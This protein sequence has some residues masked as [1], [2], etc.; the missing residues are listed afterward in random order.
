MTFLLFIAVS[1][2]A[3]R[4]RDSDSLGVEPV[5]GMNG[6]DSVRVQFPG[7]LIL[8]VEQMGVDYRTLNADSL[9]RK[10]DVTLR[11]KQLSDS[12]RRVLWTVGLRKQKIDTVR[13][14]PENV[15]LHVPASN[16]KTFL[17]SWK[18]WMEPSLVLV[19]LSGLVY[20]FYSVRSK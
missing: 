7:L 8:E 3:S 4:E 20:L 9:V 6:L 12:T 16:R 2:L 19:T 1:P 11:L 10:T 13:T 15:P 17:R 5:T 18:R 14:N